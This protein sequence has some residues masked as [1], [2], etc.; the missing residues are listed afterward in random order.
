MINK[1]VCLFEVIFFMIF[2]LL[3]INIYEFY[4]SPPHTQENYSEEINNYGL[5]ISSNNGIS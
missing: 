5:R 3:F 2:S 1:R 4:D